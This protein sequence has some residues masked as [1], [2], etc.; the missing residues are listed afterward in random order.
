MR[1]SELAFRVGAAG[2]VGRVGSG[3]VV[4]P[5][6]VARTHNRMAARPSAKPTVEHS[7]APRGNLLFLCPAANQSAKNAQTIGSHRVRGGHEDMHRDETSEKP[8]DGHAEQL[9]RY[10]N[11]TSSAIV[12]S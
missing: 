12:L 1:H 8:L 6:S 4:P 7:T 2:E 5:V 9:S 11:A 10:F 3:I